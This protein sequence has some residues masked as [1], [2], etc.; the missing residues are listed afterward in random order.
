MSD[1]D[2]IAIRV[3][4]GDKW[5][6][7]FVNELAFLTSEELENMIPAVSGPI[8]AALMADPTWD[9]NGCSHEWQRRPQHDSP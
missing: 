6:A 9:Y 5:I 8:R 4:R 1:L 7:T 2:T 3:K